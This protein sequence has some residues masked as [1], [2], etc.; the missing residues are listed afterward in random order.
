MRRLKT[1][2]SQFYRLIDPTNYRK[3]I[4]KMLELLAV[5]D[6]EV[7]LVTRCRSAGA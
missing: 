6:C 4:D 3:S 2:P 5:L 1:S 7:E